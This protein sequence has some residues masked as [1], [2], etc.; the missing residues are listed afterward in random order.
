VSRRG[1]EGRLR[2]TMRGEG[3]AYAEEGTE[4][5]G[6]YASDYEGEEREGGRLL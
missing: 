2:V 5:E 4:E 1:G 3:Q 6:E